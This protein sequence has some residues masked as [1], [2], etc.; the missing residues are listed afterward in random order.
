MVLHTFYRQRFCL[1]LPHPELKIL[2]E[3][4]CVHRCTYSI[5]MQYTHTQTQVDWDNSP[6]IFKGS[7]LPTT[8]T[9]CQKGREKYRGRANCVSEEEHGKKTRRR[10]RPRAVAEGCPDL[11]PPPKHPSKHIL[12]PQ[13]IFQG[14]KARGGS[15]STTAS[16]RTDRKLTCVLPNVN[17]PAAC[18]LASSQAGGSSWGGRR[19][20]LSDSTLSRGL[21]LLQPTPLSL[22]PCVELTCSDCVTALDDLPARMQEAGVTCCCMHGLSPTVP[23]KP[24]KTLSREIN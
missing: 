5:H 15:S 16:S 10:T 3:T 18:Q 14:E 9:S 23:L 22:S 21:I 4:V 20:T 6:K 19:Y 17:K 7:Q 2:Q 8:P 13:T 12:L 1:T 24:D 11:P